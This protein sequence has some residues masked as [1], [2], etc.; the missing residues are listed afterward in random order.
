[1]RMPRKNVVDYCYKGE[2]VKGNNDGGWVDVEGGDLCK[3]SSGYL[4]A[5]YSGFHLHLQAEFLGMA[6][7][8]KPAVCVF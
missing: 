5:L 2:E 6:G 1:M 7:S 4:F 3:S 8:A